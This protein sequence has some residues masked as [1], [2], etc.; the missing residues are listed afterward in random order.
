MTGG[1]QQKKRREEQVVEKEEGWKRGGVRGGFS[2]ESS[3]KVK[4]KERV[5]NEKQD[6]KGEMG[7]IKSQKVG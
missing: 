1:N 2:K 6:K 5:G 4:Q 7:I 3:I